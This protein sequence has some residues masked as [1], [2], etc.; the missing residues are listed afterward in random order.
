MS[1][2]I[3]TVSRHRPNLRAVQAEAGCN[4]EWSKLASFNQSSGNIAVEALIEHAQRRAGRFTER[5]AMSREQQCFSR[6][7]EG[8]RAR[9]I[10]LG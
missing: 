6:R 9:L 3:T 4:S 1:I 8:E 7:G 10:P 5:A 2:F